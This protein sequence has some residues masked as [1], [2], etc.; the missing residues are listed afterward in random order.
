MTSIVCRGA[1]LLL[2][3]ATAGCAAGNDYDMTD[4]TSMDS[5][6][7]DRA[8]IGTRDSSGAD[9]VT[10]IRSQEPRV[11]GGAVDPRLR[12]PTGRTDGTLMIDP[13]APP[14]SDTGPPPALPAEPMMKDPPEWR[15]VHRPP[16]AP[17]QS[18][19]DSR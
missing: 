1:L 18:A 11:S 2:A 3:V 14:R 10:G 6:S 12:P 17:P 5:V 7:L 9:S 19:H 15:P 16:P 4:S 13:D 8:T